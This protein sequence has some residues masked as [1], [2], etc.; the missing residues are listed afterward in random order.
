MNRGTS[1]SRYG[2][3]TWEESPCY[4]LDRIVDG[5]RAISGLAVK[6]KTSSYLSEGRS[7]S[8]RAIFFLSTT[9]WVICMAS[10]LTFFQ[11]S[12]WCDRRITC[13][14][15]CQWF[16]LQHM[17]TVTLNSVAATTLL[18]D[19]HSLP[20]HASPLGAIIQSTSQRVLYAV[21][22]LQHSWIHPV[23][24]SQFVSTQRIVT[25][26]SKICDMNCMTSR[27]VFRWFNGLVPTE[28]VSYGAGRS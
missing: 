2:A 12:L 13:G 25:G 6:S 26:S 22:W 8:R 3:L 10:G 7:S 20:S 11:H 24:R 14:P 17:Q 16:N 15:R 27:L 19:S 1:C 18:N 23:A 5:R 28:D 9:A 21:Q 4:C